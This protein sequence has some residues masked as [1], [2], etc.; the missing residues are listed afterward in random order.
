MKKNGNWIIILLIVSVAVFG[1][2]LCYAGLNSDKV[3][4]V[5]TCDTETIK[6]SVNADNTDL[7][8]GVTALD[9]KS[10]DVTASLVVEDISPLAGKER[11]I[12]YAAVDENGN[13][14]RAQR[15]LRYTDYEPPVI[16]IN[17]SLQF[18]MGY[19]V[20]PL[21]YVTAESVLDG[22]LTDKVKYSTASTFNINNEGSYE[23]EFR[24]TDSA[25]TVTYLTATIEIYNPVNQY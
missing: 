8:K 11:I 14:G 18:P 2:Y 12:T 19:H 3:P 1:A 7:L 4:P 25:G 15:T 24:V 9:K 21:Q 22:D 17:E 6:V 5:V 13:V 20:N 16:I 10:G 23:V